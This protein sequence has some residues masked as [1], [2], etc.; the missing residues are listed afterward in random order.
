MKTVDEALA[1]IAANVPAPI[2]V[3]KPLTEALIGH[4]L[5][6]DVKARESVPAFRASIVD[7]Y[8]VVVG[9]DAPS[10]KGTFPVIGSS[11]AQAGE[12]KSLRAGQVTRIT[13]GA[14][15][16]EDANAV[17]MVEDTVL[18]STT[19]DGKEEKEI[20][21]LTADYTPGENVREIGSDVTAGD[22]ILRK[23]E[24]IT[25]VGGE[26]GL[27]A[28]VGTREVSVYSKPVISVL[29]TGDEIVP[30]DHKDDLR[31]G[32][33]RDTNRPTLLQSIKNTGFEGVDMGIASDKVG[34]LEA[35]LRDAMRASDVVI[36]TGGVSMGE[37]DLLKSTIEHRLGGTIH[38]GRVSMKPGKPTTF[39]TVPCKD[40]DGVRST[41]VIFS[42]PGNP[43]SAVVTYHLFVLPALHA[44]SGIKPVGLPLVSV[45]L[46]DRVRCDAKRQEY[47]RA[48]VTCSASGLRAHSTGGQRSS[49]I[50][51]FKGANGLLKLPLIDGYLEKGDSVPALLLGPL[52]STMS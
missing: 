32:E 29:S 23:G 37:L 36:T 33:V 11:T 13:T 28:S 9:G 16:P 18:V 24:G 2:E 8:A 25:D 3:T 26:F 40:S 44:M 22:T 19:D 27:L 43:A 41:K 5:A 45:V 35:K 42:L 34:Q 30:Y 7:G 4:V 31:Y 14:P 39:A 51:S 12:A 49:R 17:V 21:I 15:L 10:I 52:Q 6:A 1:L 50:G 20:R 46:E 48:I 38:F 47:S